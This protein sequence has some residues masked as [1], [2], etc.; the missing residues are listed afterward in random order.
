MADR[1]GL[2][3]DPEERL[4]YRGRLRSGRAVAVTDERLLIAGEERT[5]SIPYTNVSEVTN[6]RFDWFLAI[7]SL[8]LCG[9]GVLSLDENVLLG[10]GMVVFGAWSLLRTYRKRDRVRIHTHSRP[11]PIEVFPADVDALYA[12]LE[13]AVAAVRERADG[14]GRE[15]A[16]EG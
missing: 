9:V 8:A 12:A 11:K 10:V 4:R 2:E 13:P 6:E 14:R 16:R 7:M 5:E 15:D 1:R 3:L